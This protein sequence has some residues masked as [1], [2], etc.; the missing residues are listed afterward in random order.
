M[1]KFVIIPVKNLLQEI[2]P[3]SINILNLRNVHDYLTSRMV[4]NGSLEKCLVW[5][6]SIAIGLL[7]PILQARADDVKQQEWA[8]GMNYY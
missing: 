5:C 8:I 3:I 2:V 4:L 1:L 6:E 7:C